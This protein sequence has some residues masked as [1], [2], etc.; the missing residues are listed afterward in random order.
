MTMVLEPLCAAETVV[1]ATEVRE[2][3]GSVDRALALGERLVAA[4]ETFAL[5][6][7]LSDTGVVELPPVVGSEADRAHLQTVGPL[8]LAAELESARLV[9]AAETLAGLFASGGLSADPGPAAP[10]LTA[11]WRGRRER[12]VEN[13]RRALYARMFGQTTGTTL[14]ARRAINADFET[15]MIDLTEALS[16]LNAAPL[17]PPGADFAA[18][19]A[20]GQL[21]ANLV[22]RSGGMAAFA[23]RDLLE[24]IKAAL[25]IFKQPA[26]QAAVGARTV[27][28]AV[29]AVTR[30]YLRE[31]DAEI[32]L[33]VTRGKAGLLVLAWLAE[34]FL[35]LEGEGELVAPAHPVVGAGLT[36]LRASLSLAERKTAG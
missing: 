11:F 25:A 20:A 35:Q 5:Q 30:L 19:V 2:E 14:A 6:F 26:V 13:E 24:T 15:L 33:H 4:V 12:F 1:T 8:Y 18:R 32:A 17:A 3:A 22:S 16:K 21:A 7:D 34:V 29:R 10:L 28:G 9:A 36:W 23:A 27:W 31:E